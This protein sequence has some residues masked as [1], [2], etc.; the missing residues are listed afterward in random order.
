MLGDAGLLDRFQVVIS[1]EE[2]EHGK[3]APDLFLAA[4]RRL[5]A[6]PADCVVIEDSDPGVRAAHAAGMR[7]IAVPYLPDQPLARSYHDA[8]LL[9]AGGMG[10]LD[11]D[12]VLA[13]IR[14]PADT[15]RLA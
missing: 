11:P 8:D 13:W 10:A 5:G 14:P 2:V 4:A 6:E 7:C 9:I 1:A 12:D 15:D 3:P